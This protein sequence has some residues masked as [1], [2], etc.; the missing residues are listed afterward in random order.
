MG[1]GRRE[2]VTLVG[3]RVVPLI[4]VGLALGLAA[5]AALSGLIANQLWGVSPTEPATYAAVSVVLALVSLL[6]CLGPVRRAIAV[7][8][9]VV[10]RCE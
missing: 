7:D 4:A 6:A 1:A 8:P 3:R 5:A 2:I 10:L 9:T